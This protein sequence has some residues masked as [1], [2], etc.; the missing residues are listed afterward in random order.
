MEDETSADKLTRLIR[1]LDSTT[2]AALHHQPMLP[3]EEKQKEAIFYTA[4]QIINGET[5]EVGSPSKDVVFSLDPQVGEWG[6]VPVRRQEIPSWERYGFSP[7]KFLEWRQAGLTIEDAPHWHLWEDPLRVTEWKKTNIPPSE[8][9]IW[10]KYGASPDVAKKW[11][12]MYVGYPL[13]EVAKWLTTFPNA[14][15]QQIQELIHKNF[16]L[17]EA[18]DWVRQDIPLADILIWKT[19]KHSIYHAKHLHSQG[20]APQQA[21]FQQP[22]KIIKG[23]TWWRVSKELQ[24]NNWS[25]ISVS[26]GWAPKETTI[27]IQQGDKTATL[28]FKGRRFIEGWGDQYYPASNLKLFIK[29]IRPYQ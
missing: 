22:E 10:D 12:Q 18:R 20:V 17:E 23:F 14:P 8:C 24:K 1:W 2:K 28:R 19:K 3:L 16:S 15:M 7:Q 21:A 25:V 26:P 4:Q 6:R 11:D 27:K 5:E 13:D 9:A 29:S